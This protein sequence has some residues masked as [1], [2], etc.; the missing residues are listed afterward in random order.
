MQGKSYWDDWEA[1]EA[2]RQN[3]PLQRGDPFSRTANIRFLKATDEAIAQ[4][5]PRPPA[6]GSRPPLATP[7]Q[8]K[9]A[10]QRAIL[11]MIKCQNH[12]AKPASTQRPSDDANW[13]F[14]EAEQ[15]RADEWPALAALRGQRLGL[16]GCDATA[17]T[18]AEIAHD[19][20]DM[21]ILV[22]DPDHSLA[23][24]LAQGV[25]HSCD[26]LDE[27]IPNCDFVS[28]HLPQNNS[29]RHLINSARLDLFK[30]DAALINISARALVDEVSL[31][32]SLWFETI[33]AAGFD[34]YPGEPDFGDL[35]LSTHLVILRDD[36]SEKERERLETAL[37]RTPKDRVA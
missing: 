7:H 33:G 11:L 28:L 35:F 34:L 29:T 20:L 15:D 9:R 3:A 1:F 12:L 18:L 2:P 24:R 5:A 23:K 14:W 17:Q 36:E 22:F 21:E 19:Q 6:A 37:A 4:P 10:A 31:A 25:Y 26:A 27:M 13:Q 16:V 30:A 32:R 8:Q